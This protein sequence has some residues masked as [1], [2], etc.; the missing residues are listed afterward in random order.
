MQLR[1][2]QMSRFKRARPVAPPNTVLPWMENTGAYLHPLDGFLIL[3]KFAVNNLIIINEWRLRGVV[4]RMMDCPISH[5]FD[6]LSVFGH[7]VGRAKFNE[8]VKSK[9]DD[10]RVIN[11]P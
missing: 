9:P 5:I 11:R 1:A 6:C 4:I 3:V 2:Y 8:Q 7:D 10:H